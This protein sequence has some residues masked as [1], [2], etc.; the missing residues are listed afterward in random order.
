MRRSDGSRGAFTIVELL[1]VVGVIAVLASLLLAAVRRAHEPARSSQCRWHLKQLGLALHN[2]HLAWN[3][4]PPGY[5]TE[6]RPA[7]DVA[8]AVEVGPGW[9]WGAMAMGYMEGMAAPYNAINFHLPIAA[10]ASRTARTAEMGTFLCPSEGRPGPVSFHAPQ[11]AILPDPLPPSSY[12]GCGGTAVD[13]PAE[14]GDGM[15]GRNVVRTLRD[16][17]DGAAHTFLV[18]ERSRDLADA[19]WAGVV[20][21]TVHATAPTWPVRSSGHPRAMVLGFADSPLSPSTRGLN[22]TRAGHAAFRGPHPDGAVFAMV[23]GSVRFLKDSMHPATFSAHATRAG[24]EA[25]PPDGD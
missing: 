20:P 3:A 17:V 7:P 25:I 19:T 2:Y 22:S 8:G 21:G 12:I 13:P 4:F 5:L 10:P 9:A 16:A 24:G 18:G 6:V 15:F 23:D 14:G 1:V 11:D